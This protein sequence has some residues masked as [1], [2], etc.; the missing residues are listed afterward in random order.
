MPVTICVGGGHVWRWHVGHA[1][2][3][4]T[5]Q[6][7]SHRGVVVCL[8]SAASYSSN[9]WTYPSRRPRQLICNLSCCSFAARNLMTFRCLQ[10]ILYLMLKLWTTERFLNCEC[11]LCCILCT[12]RVPNCGKY[13]V[14][15]ACH[16][17][18]YT[19][20]CTCAELCYVLCT[21]RVPNCVLYCVLHAC[22]IVLC[23]VYCTRAELCFKLCT[24][25][26]PICV[27]YCVLHVCLISSYVFAC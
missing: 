10:I 14:L 11:E 13:C 2:P 20:Y 8:S 22:R 23:T 12:A 19:V 3:V 27:M 17:V 1:S 25:R 26:V 16:I 4:G 7:G 24:A 5:D 21:A 15:H 9:A 6:S 18:F